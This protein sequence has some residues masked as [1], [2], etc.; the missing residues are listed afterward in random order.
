MHAHLQTTD[1]PAPL[2]ANAMRRSISVSLFTLMNRCEPDQ[3]F[4]VI[5][6]ILVLLDDHLTNR[7]PLLSYV[8]EARFPK[9]K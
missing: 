7:R 9:H 3:E 2:T 4:Q 6:M 5:A 1:P 8:D